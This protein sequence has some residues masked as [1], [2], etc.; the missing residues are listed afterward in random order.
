VTRTFMGANGLS[1][2]IEPAG[3][4]Q[5]APGNGG[6]YQSVATAPTDGSQVFASHRH[7]VVGTPR[8]PEKVAHWSSRTSR[9]ARRGVRP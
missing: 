4:M 5:T 9:R 3:P 6:N 2:A 7:G 8:K 1:G